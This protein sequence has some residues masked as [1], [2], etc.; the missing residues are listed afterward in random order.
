MKTTTTRWKVAPIITAVT[1]RPVRFGGRRSSSTFDEKLSFIYCH[2]SILAYTAVTY[3]YSTTI[4]DIHEP[5]KRVY[6]G[7][8]NTPSSLVSF[9]LVSN[10]SHRNILYNAP[11]SSL[12]SQRRYPFC[13]CI[14]FG[15]L[16]HSTCTDT[17]IL[18][19]LPASSLVPCT[20]SG[21][22]NFTSW[23]YHILYQFRSS[24]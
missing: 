24:M 1:L 4:C 11:C 9:I 23:L 5:M 13:I 3:T 2:R 14:T 22:T 18:A 8:K 15:Y 17:Y 20:L 19:F 10:S 7:H 16:P 12:H 21:R 6:D